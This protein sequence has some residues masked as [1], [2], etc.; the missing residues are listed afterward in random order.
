VAR[1]HSKSHTCTCRT[2]GDAGHARTVA[3]QVYSSS[4]STSC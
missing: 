3:V 4:S 2:K 1:S